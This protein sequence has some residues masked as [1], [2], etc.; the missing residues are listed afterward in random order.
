M[1]PLAPLAGGDLLGA[2]LQVYSNGFGTWYYSGRSTASIGWLSN[3][4]SLP[5]PLTGDVVADGLGPFAKS[6]PGGF[7][8][9]DSYVSG[10]GAAGW[11]EFDVITQLQADLDAGRNYSVFVLSTSRDTS[12]SLASAETGMGPRV[13]ALST[14]PEPATVVWLMGV[15]A[16]L[17]AVLR[18]RR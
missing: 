12:G 18:R 13:M 8:V 14:I 5:T 7:L 9:Y 15:A 1:I 3:A 11:Q 17:G 6:R 4:V 2:T 16:L 10:S